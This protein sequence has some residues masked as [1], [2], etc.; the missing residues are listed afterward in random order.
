MVFG[1]VVPQIISVFAPM[2]KEVALPYAVAYPVEAHVNCLRSTLLHGVVDDARGAG[3]VG[4]D[5]RGRLRVAKVFESGT[6]PRRV[7]GI[8]EERSHFG[9]G[10]GGQD[11]PH[12]GTRSVDGYVDGWWHTVGRRRE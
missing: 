12:D 8:V 10:C 6:K 2:N 11:N 9:F 5:W 7:F 1:E 4:L 3:I